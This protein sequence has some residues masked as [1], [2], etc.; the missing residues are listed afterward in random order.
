MNSEKLHDWLQVVGM[1][2]I[3]VSLIFV[4][5]QLRQSEDAARADMSQGSVV[6]AVE[7]S[8][9]MAE[10][11]DVWLRACAGDELSE[12]ERSIANNIYSRWVQHNFVSFARHNSTEIGFVKPSD[13][14]DVFAANIHR[15]PG[16]RQMTSSYRDWSDF[17]VRNDDNLIKRRYRE[18]IFER[19]SELEKEEP[20]PKSDIAWC[21]S[22]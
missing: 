4:G 14:T 16:F 8:A 6:I 18:K 11:S 3:V 10:H 20:D 1:A 19:L 9:L 12:S 5:L 7:L 13:F 15:Y 17:G 22:R 2:A 21:G